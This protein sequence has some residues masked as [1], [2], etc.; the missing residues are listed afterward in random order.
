MDYYYLIDDIVRR[1][2]FLLEI[3][4]TSP[5]PAFFV[6]K[7]PRAKHI[8]LTLTHAVNVSIIYFL[9]GWK[10]ALFFAVYPMC[11][12]CTAWIT[13]GYY[14]I[15]TFFTLTSIF[16]LVKFPGIVGALLGATFFTAAL[17]STI[18]CIAIPFIF[19]V[20]PPMTGLALF[21][22]LT[23]YLF[24]RRFRIGFKKRNLGKGD[25]IT[26]RKAILVPKVLAYYIKN[27]V[28]PDKLAFFR[29]YGFEYG[30]DPQVKI[31]LETVNQEFYESL[32]LIFFFCFFGLLTS[33]LGLCIFLAG[34]LPFTQWK[35]L[36][37]FVAERYLYL[38]SVGWCLMLAGAL[39]NIWLL[40][41]VFAIAGAYAWRSHKYIPAFKNIETLYENGIQQFPQCVSNYVNLAERK[42][43]IGKS[44]DAYKLLVKGLEIHPQSFLCHANMAAYWL[45]I[46]QPER[47]RYHTQMAIQYSENRGMAYNVFRQQMQHI[48][49]GMKMMAEGRAQVDKMLAEIRA[50]EKK[51]AET[52][53]EA[54]NVV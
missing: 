10:A 32:A 54:A 46:N 23:F 41:V 34:L 29:E 36:G 14:Q 16:F 26:I 12:S 51:A 21:W 44:Y 7:P 20:M 45:S 48:T 17:G 33:P 27:V 38:P 37:Q 47:G 1:W 5:N 4:E 15:T 39:S 19:L 24:G 28:W 3:P 9:W 25:P 30:K 2:G 11:V 35:V 53:K 13:G 31:K 40:P 49:N 52:P 22:P 42:L 8:F 6:T 50:E 43:H 18:N